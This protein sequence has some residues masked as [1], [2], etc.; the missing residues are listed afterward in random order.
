MIFFFQ[1]KYA[2]EFYK[3]FNGNAFNSIEPEICHLIYVVKVET[4]KSSEVSLVTEWFSL[5]GQQ[6]GSIVGKIGYEDCC[7]E[8]V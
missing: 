7:A 8:I 6:I 3:Y 2:D 4:A 1:Q 5:V